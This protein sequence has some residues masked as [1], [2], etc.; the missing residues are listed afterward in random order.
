MIRGV[1][2]SMDY[3][4]GDQLDVSRRRGLRRISGVLYTVQ[5]IREKLPG[6]LA[7]DLAAI[8]RWRKRFDRNPL[9]VRVQDKFAVR[10]YAAE[11]G[12]ATAEVLHATDDPGTIPFTDLPSSYMIKATH[13]SGWNILCLNSQHYLF[14][15]GTDFVE[16]LE[17]QDP[18]SAPGQ[19]RLSREEVVE[20][21]QGWLRTA[22]M[23]AEWAYRHIPPRIV[24]EP[25]LTQ[26]RGSELLDYRFYTFD[27]V[28]KAVNV[29]SPRYVRDKLEAVFDADW[30]L[31][32]LSRNDEVVPDVLPAEPETLADMTAAAGRLGKGLGFARI[33][34]Y[35]TAGGIILGE[36]TIYPQA[37][38]RG[39]P[40]LCPHFNRWLGDQWALTPTQRRQV[41]AW[42]ATLMLSDMI[43]SA[44]CRFRH[45]S[46]LGA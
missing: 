23:P 39:T 20:V 13:G 40:T 30:N 3:V 14:G 38:G 36:I 5:E 25:R 43:N 1:H 17:S 19:R 34:I 21:C 44:R 2:L 15:D 29:D 18:M 33:D 37:G 11:R 28:V 45:Q 9:F 26:R 32:E 41:V 10:E 6:Y 46:S 42:N 31:V 35:D 24:I 8:I 12:V 7:V 4:G 16:L 22:F 27:G